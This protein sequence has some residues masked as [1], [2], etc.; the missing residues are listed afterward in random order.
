MRFQRK[1]GTAKSCA[2]VAATL[3]KPYIFTRAVSQEIAEELGF[4]SSDSSEEEVLTTRV[5][6]RRVIIQV[7]AK[8]LRVNAASDEQAEGS[9]ATRFIACCRVELFGLSPMSLDIL[10][11]K[12]FLLQWVS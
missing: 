2:C 8:F 1:E 3:W 5:V 6:R 11:S 12:F 9:A 10:C 7:T 4:M